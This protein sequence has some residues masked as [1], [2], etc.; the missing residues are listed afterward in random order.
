MTTLEDMH[1]LQRLQLQ[2]IG[3]EPPWWRPW[4]RYKWR[5][6][7]DAIMATEFHRPRRVSSATG[8]WTQVFQPYGL[9]REV[10]PDEERTAS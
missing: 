2:A 10:W 1:R 6:A 3:K 9:P 8:D 7:R 5:R 4:L